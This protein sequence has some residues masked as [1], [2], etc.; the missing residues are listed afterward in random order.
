MDR[1]EHD[2]K[3]LYFQF[4]QSAMRARAKAKQRY[5]KLITG[6][7]PTTGRQPLGFWKNVS[8]EDGRTMRDEKATRNRPFSRRPILR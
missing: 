3:G 6:L 1:G 5:T 7:P 2:T 4:F 8:G